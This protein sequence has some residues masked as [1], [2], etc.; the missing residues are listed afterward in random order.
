MIICHMGEPFTPTVIQ[1]VGYAAVTERTN[2]GFDVFEDMSRPRARPF[3]INDEE[4]VWT[5]ERLS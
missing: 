5:F 2:I 3:D 4:T 1:S